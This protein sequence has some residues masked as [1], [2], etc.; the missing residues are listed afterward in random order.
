LS[1][2]KTYISTL[3][4]IVCIIFII[5]NV[6]YVAK[7]NSFKKIILFIERKS[8]Y[9]NPLATNYKKILYY[10]SLI[11]SHLHIKNCFINSICIHKILKLNSYEPT[12]HIGVDKVKNFKSHAWIE[13]NSKKIFNSED[14]EYNE[15][16]V[17]NWTQ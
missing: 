13:L 1:S 12:L 16:L 11:A 5:L 3:F 10:Y 6:C 4:L 2:F 17:L 8:L 14:R 7:V 9:R 15:I